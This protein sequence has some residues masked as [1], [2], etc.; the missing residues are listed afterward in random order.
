MDFGR[1]WFLDWSRGCK[2]R[3]SGGRPGEGAR[4][5][6]VVK[7]RMD[8]SNGSTSLLGQK[9]FDKLSFLLGVAVEDSRELSVCLF[10]STRRERGGGP[11]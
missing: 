3:W 4:F 11:A 1:E 8:T 2:E 10:Q 9:P 5:S 7:F 6:K